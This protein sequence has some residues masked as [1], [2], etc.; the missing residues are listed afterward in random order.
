MIN[1]GKDDIAIIGMGF[2]FPKA[3]TQDEFWKILKGKVECIDEFPENRRKDVEKYLSKK[4]QV[5]MNSLKFEKGAYLDEID[6]FAANKFHI[7]EQEARLIDPSQ[8]LFL[9]VS[10][11]TL[12]DAGYAGTRMI[13]RNVGVYI[14]YNNKNARDYMGMVEEYE[15][16]SLSVAYTGNLASIIPSRISYYMD[17]KGPT[18]LIDTACSSSIVA[19]HTAISG[20]KNGDCTSALVGGISISMFPLKKEESEK[21]GVDSEDGRSRTFDVESHGTGWGEGIGAVMIKPVKE[22]LEA[23]DHI[24][25]IVKGSAINQDGY[26]MGITIPNMESQTA[27]IQAAIENSG[28]NPEKISYIEAHGTGTRIGDPV[29]IEA[30]KKAYEKYTDKKQFCG[31]G[32]VKTNIGHLQTAAG[33]ASLIKLVLSLNHNQIPPTLNFVQPNYSISFEDSP[34]YPVCELRNFPQDRGRQYCALSAF[35]FSGTNSHIILESMQNSI[36]NEQKESEEVVTI[37][38]ENEELL[39]KMLNKY[40]TFLDKD[41]SSLSDIAYTS[42]V[43]RE[44]FNCRVAFLASNKKE[45]REKITSFLMSEPEQLANQ[46]IY[47]GFPVI[48]KKNAEIEEGQ[49]ITKKEQKEYTKQATEIALSDRSKSE[50]IKELCLLYIKGADVRWDCFYQSEVSKKKIVSIPVT[51]LKKVSCWVDT[52]EENE[53]VGLQYNPYWRF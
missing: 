12:E 11:E 25:A 2:R 26:S 43:G 45:L 35:G 4:K 9:E 39:T 44:H 7:T 37:S 6:L 50:K 53:H 5:E 46:E 16:D 18:M 10:Y 8:R 15:K 27:V 49:L 36:E 13:D 20:I 34:V 38:A 42:N 21:I 28:V 3:N 31:I 32:S 30:I 33:I 29:E 22:A 14:G 17:F 48:G 51:A 23:G 24:Y 47:Y 40:L 41:K 52:R 19:L 1:H